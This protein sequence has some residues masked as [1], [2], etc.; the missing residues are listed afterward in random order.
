MRQTELKERIANFG[1]VLVYMKNVIKPR[2]YNGKQGNY[3]I[4]QQRD[5]SV[6]DCEIKISSLISRKD[7]ECPTVV[8]KTSFNSVPKTV[9]NGLCYKQQFECDDIKE[10]A[11]PSVCIYLEPTDEAYKTD[12]KT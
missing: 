1:H 8:D 5:D 9:Q 12:K 4:Q 3:L 2:L 6:I 11:S 10:T 7:C